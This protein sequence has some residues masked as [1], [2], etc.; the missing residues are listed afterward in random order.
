MVIPPNHTFPLAEMFVHWR[1][2]FLPFSFAAAPAQLQHWYHHRLFVALLSFIIYAASKP[3]KALY[4]Q[5][6]A[7]REITLGSA[8]TLQT[9]SWSLR[10][11]QDKG[12]KTTTHWGRNELSNQQ[13]SRKRSRKAPSHCGWNYSEHFETP[14]CQGLSRFHKPEQCSAEG[15]PFCW[16]Q[17]LEAEN[18]YTFLQSHC[19][20]SNS[21]PELIQKASPCLLSYMWSWVNTLVHAHLIGV[22]RY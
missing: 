3:R 5:V 7:S 16:V 15:M 14:W 10:V 1:K 12:G 2:L 17:A 11:N 20:N 8:G 4:K 21:H 9:T 18:K 6:Q 22:L 19:Q 13:E